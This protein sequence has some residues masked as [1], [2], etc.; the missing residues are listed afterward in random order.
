M[1]DPLSNVS[2]LTPV[3][4]PWSEPFAFSSRSVHPRVASRP[5][6]IRTLK[7]LYT[8]KERVELVSVVAVVPARGGSKGVPGKNLRRIAGRSLVARAVDAALAAESID[9]V[10]VSTDDV[11]IA[12][13]ARRA[14]AE[15][16]NRP[17]D[18][19]DDT[20]SSEAA[21]LHALAGLDAKPE[22]V[23]FVQA[24]SPFINP[25]D[26]DSA[27]HRVL[28]AREDVVFAAVRT[29][30]FLWRQT[31][32]GAVGVNHD[33]SIR[34]RRQ[35]RDE[36]FQETGA[37]YVMRAEGFVRGGHR[38]FGRV[39][40][41]EVDSA[42]AIEIDT[43]RELELAGLIAPLFSPVTS[44]D[45]EALI[46]DFDGVHTDDRALID[47][48]G[49]EFVTVSRADGAGVE[50][51]RR[52]GFPVL[53]LSRETNPV[54]VARAR[55]LDVEVLHGERDKAEALTAWADRAGIEL[56]RSAYLGNDVNDLPAMALVGWPIA[57]ADA[58]PLVLA[59]ARHVL[60]RG[61]GSGA[62]RELADLILARKS[63]TDSLTTDESNERKGSVQPWQL[64]LAE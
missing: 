64:Q 21:V 44:I 6:A 33:A 60:Q 59:A 26:L 38:F 42:R 50:A 62:V 37:F 45:V 39:G 31:A 14:G 11:E 25:A 57:V 5:T 36:Q 8:R 34:P 58:H 4:L 52:A 20:A 23:V 3:R 43:V 27:V 16:V 13:E 9:R 10:L 40:V 18:I 28:S 7:S 22:I 17:A 51:L 61:G 47:S 24:T 19:A 30:A 12:A 1:A 56:A 53:I 54:V 29:H 49:N 63:G 2:K 15:V 41:H 46:T 32:D 35:D 55:K 48:D